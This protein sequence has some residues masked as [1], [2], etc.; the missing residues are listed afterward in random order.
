M[1]P[2]GLPPHDNI[3]LEFENNEDLS[4]T[5]VRHLLIACWVIF[6][7]FSKFTFSQ[8]KFRITIRVSDSLDP[9]QDRQ[10]VSPD[11]G[12]NCLQSL[13]GDD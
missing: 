7:A 1:Y 13:T 10:N 11:L 5:Q 12:P 2:M 3:R 4:G 9:D 8:K 6:H